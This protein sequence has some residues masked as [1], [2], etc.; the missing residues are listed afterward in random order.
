M[1]RVRDTGLTIAVEH[2]TGRL[3]EG[4]EVR[5]AY[6]RSGIRAWVDPFT[7]RMA[8]ACWRADF[9]IAL[10]GACTLAELASCSVPALFV[11]L[12]RHAGAHQTANLHAAQSRAALWWVS[13]DDWC[14]EALATRL[15]E[16]LA[17]PEAL[18]SQ[19]AQLHGLATPDAA[20][21][22]VAACE[23]LLG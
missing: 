2:F 1:E 17:K 23:E 7:D 10:A 16:L 6:K 12:A 14:T 19:A 20:R 11:P 18:E 22:I 21:R 15:A 13:E 8:E 9:A 5:A 4:S 3:Y